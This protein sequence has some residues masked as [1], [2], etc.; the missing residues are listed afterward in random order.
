ME[1]KKYAR[2]FY[3]NAEL[4]EQMAE[5]FGLSFDMIEEDDALIITEEAEDLFN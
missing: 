3:A 5:F 1:M 4:Q 2:P